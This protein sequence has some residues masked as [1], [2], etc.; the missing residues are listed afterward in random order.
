MVK[1]ACDLETGL[2]ATVICEQEVAVR[3]QLNG[4][5]RSQAL[6]KAALWQAT[7]SLPPR[8]IAGQVVEGALRCGQLRALF[9]SV[10]RPICRLPRSGLRPERSDQIAP[11]LDVDHVFVRIRA[12]EDERTGVLANLYDVQGC[13]RH[14]PTRRNPHAVAELN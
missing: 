8:G 6:R 12:S 11:G 14:G 7:P 1:I 5:G 4:Q 10:I 3:H 13:A 9:K 2:A